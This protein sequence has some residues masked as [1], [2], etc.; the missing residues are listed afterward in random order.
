MI[1]A[2]QAAE[3]ADSVTNTQ[4]AKELA[5]FENEIESAAKKGSHSFQSAKSLSS[6]VKK[7][8]ESRGFKITSSYDPRD[9][10]SWITISW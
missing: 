6:P 7:E 2:K 9:S 1:T 10:D 5:F 8:L 3:I 4:A